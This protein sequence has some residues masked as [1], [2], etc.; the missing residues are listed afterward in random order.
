MA[1]GYWPLSVLQLS[2]FPTSLPALCKVQVTSNTTFAEHQTLKLA[3]RPR[4]DHSDLEFEPNMSQVQILAAP[5][6]LS[7]FLACVLFE[8]NTSALCTHHKGFLATQRR[9]NPSKHCTLKDTWEAGMRVQRAHTCALLT[10][11]LESVP[12][13]VTW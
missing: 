8:P 7:I 5:Y 11:T 2:S 9:C 3:Q 6:V 10:A 13:T 4:G 1:C 12:G